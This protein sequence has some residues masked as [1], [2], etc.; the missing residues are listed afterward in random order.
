MRHAATDE[1]GGKAQAVFERRAGISQGGCG[2]RARR[3]PGVRHFVDFR[4]K[5]K[6]SCST[7]FLGDAT[8]ENTPT[9]FSITARRARCR[10]VHAEA[11]APSARCGH[12][13][14]ASFDD[15]G[16]KH[17]PTCCLT[18]ARA[19]ISN[20]L[21]LVSLRSVSPNFDGRWNSFSIEIV[22]DFRSN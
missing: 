12:V 6:T 18:P 10:S 5:K 4:N 22:R 11:F 13:P 14:T 2:R 16:R 19:V 15:E 21:L 8:P 9:C 3:R 7:C 17:T 20:T 1:R